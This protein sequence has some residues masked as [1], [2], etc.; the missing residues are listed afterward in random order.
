MTLAEESDLR[1][2]SHTATAGDHSLMQKAPA[3][4]AHVGQAAQ[5]RAQSTPRSVMFSRKLV[6]GLESSVIR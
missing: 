6:A 2:G 5:R 1:V 3:L 4:F